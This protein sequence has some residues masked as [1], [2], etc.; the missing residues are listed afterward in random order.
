M[1]GQF[2]RFK[3]RQRRE[4]V[5]TFAN[6]METYAR[7]LKFVSESAGDKQYRQDERALNIRLRVGESYAIRA[8]DNPDYYF[9]VII[10]PNPFTGGYKKVMSQFPVYGDPPPGMQT[11]SAEQVFKQ[12]RELNGDGAS[13]NFQA[14]P[15]RGV[16]GK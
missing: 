13:T 6:S 16:G 5:N 10:Q 2:K 9:T 14:F 7:T 3:E 4:A 1:K 15:F 8:T 11:V 12:F